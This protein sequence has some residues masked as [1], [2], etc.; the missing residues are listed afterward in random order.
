MNT[1]DHVPSK[2][3]PKRHFKFAW[4]LLLSTFMNLRKMK[5]IS[6]IYTL[7][8]HRFCCFHTSVNLRKMKFISYIYTLFL[9]RFCCFHTSV[10][11]RK[12]K[13][14]SYIY[15]LFLHRF[16]SLFVEFWFKSCNYSGKET[17]YYG[18]FGYYVQQPSLWHNV[19]RTLRRPVNYCIFLW[20]CLRVT[21]RERVPFMGVWTSSVQ[22]RFI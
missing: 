2:W 5:F 18:V 1:T 3:C 8:L 7:F 11:L 15:T 10:N 21:S 17:L 6:Y 14:I 9:H 12:M 16:C 4:D 19:S 13:F 22:N 20:R